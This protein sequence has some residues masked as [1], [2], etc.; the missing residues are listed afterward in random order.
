MKKI[1]YP[2]PSPCTK[3]A[4]ATRLYPF[5]TGKY[6]LAQLNALLDRCRLRPAL[7]CMGYRRHSRLLSPEVQLLIYAAYHSEKLRAA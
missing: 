7:A 5:C 2:L 4:F 3:Q 1:D 6:A